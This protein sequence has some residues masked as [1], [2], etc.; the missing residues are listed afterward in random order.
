MTT[1]YRFPHD[2]RCTRTRDS[3][4]RLEQWTFVR[5]AASARGVP[6]T[7]DSQLLHTS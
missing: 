5:A 3:V 4:D 2:E 1:P 6:E 7:P